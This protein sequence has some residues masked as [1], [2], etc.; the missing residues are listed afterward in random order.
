LGITNKGTFFVV[1]TVSSLLVRFVAGRLSDKKGRVFVLRIAFI[2][3]VISVTALGLASS[4]A[5]LLSAA[6]LYGISTGL[7]S[8]ASSAWTADLSS[9]SHRG[10]GIATMYI[11]L[12]AG[13]GLGAMVAGWVFKDRL[14]RVPYIFYGCA[15]MNVLGLV[16]LVMRE[17]RKAIMAEFN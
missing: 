13:I 15:V 9:E 8:P 17:R 1:Y 2:L 16:Y 3:N 6:F 5:L 4:A 12:E 7:F 10:R 11:A 14:E